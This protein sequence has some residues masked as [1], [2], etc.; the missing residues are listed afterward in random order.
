V[1]QSPELRNYAPARALPVKAPLPAKVAE[2]LGWPKQEGYV[3]GAYQT[4]K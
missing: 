2:L 4:G 3:P 1:L